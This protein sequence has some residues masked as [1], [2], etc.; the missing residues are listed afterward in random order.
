M[1]HLCARTLKAVSVVVI[2]LC[3]A[4]E[5]EAAQAGNGLSGYWPGDDGT[6]PTVAAD[7]SGN[8]NNGTYTGSATTSTASKAPLLFANPS[9]MSFNGTSA[10][11]DVPTF[12]WPTGGPVTV[13]FW[14]FV[15]TADV[16]TSSAFTVGN[17]DTPNR[18]HA[19]CPYSDNTVYWDYGTATTGSGR[20]SASYAGHLDVWTHVAL[21]SAGTGGTFQ[22]I[23]FNGTLAGSVATSSGPTVPLSGAQ[24]GAW[25]GSSLYEKGMID[26]F[27]IY[28]R[29]L[30]VTEIQ[31]LA[32][33]N[34]G[35]SAPTGLAAVPGNAQI[36]LTWNPVSG[37]TGYNLKSATVS[38]GPY[39]PVATNI[40]ATTFT[41]T[42]LTNGTIYYY[43]VSAISFGEGANSAEISAA[44]VAPPP[45]T[46]KIG[47]DSH[48]CGMGASRS[49]G[50]DFFA[51]AALLLAVL[52]TAGRRPVWDSPRS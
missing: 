35:P 47:N 21:V 46:Q 6:S 19:H 4:I 40:S 14:N 43:V 16:K 41:D 23:Y 48:K 33:G 52:A 50:L 7:A 36:N 18:F 32:S 29:V 1:R 11:V 44:P 38:G 5:A 30:S 42:G 24:I 8:G 9:S 39:S 51:I 10:Y 45:R 28:N 27:R 3:A 25:T 12:A 31:G 37:A 17:M 13:C 2:V 26:D 20:V 34:S 15:A 22:A 49:G